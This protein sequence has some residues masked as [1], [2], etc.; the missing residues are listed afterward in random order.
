MIFI[1][2]VGYIPGCMGPIPPAPLKRRFSI[3]ILSAS[4]KHRHQCI[5]TINA[6]SKKEI[7]QMERPK[8]PACSSSQKAHCLLLKSISESKHLHQAILQHIVYRVLIGLTGTAW[9]H[10]GSKRS[11]TKVSNCRPLEPEEQRINMAIGTFSLFDMVFNLEISNNIYLEYDVIKKIYSCI[12]QSCM[13]VVFD[14][15]PVLHTCYVSSL[16][17]HRRVIA[18][19]PGS[20]RDWQSWGWHRWSR[21][22]ELIIMQVHHPKGG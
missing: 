14:T 1:P 7:K 3:A 6:A 19:A 5:K 22:N 9:S 15:C 8:I 16:T 17:F 10:T 21:R 20:L 18:T 4:L 13:F 2:V 11:S 12:A